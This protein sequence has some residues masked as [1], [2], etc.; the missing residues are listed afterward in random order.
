MG[1]VKQQ[2][3]GFGNLVLLTPSMPNC[4]FPS[5][6]AFESSCTRGHMVCKAENISCLALYRK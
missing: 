5:M 3:A 6:A 2:A 1:V 4:L